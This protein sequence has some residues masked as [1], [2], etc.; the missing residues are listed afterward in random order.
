MRSTAVLLS[1]CLAA[2]GVL[3]AQEAKPAGAPEAQQAPTEAI[4]GPTF[5]V[6]KGT[7]ILLSMINSISTKTAADGDKVYLESVFP[8]LSGGKVVIPPG[9][10]V[11]G[12]VTHIKRPGK[13]KGRG[14]FYLKFDSLTLPNGTTRDFRAQITNL[15]GRASESLD[16][17]EG[18]IKSEGNKAGDAKTVGETVMIG[19]GVG[20]L[21]GSVAGS[22]GMG[23]G[24]G[25]AAGAAAGLLGVLLSRGPDAVLAKGTTLEMVLDRTLIFEESEIEFTAQMSRPGASNGSG[26]LPSKRL[27]NQVPGSRGPLGTRR[28]Y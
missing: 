23:A 10:Y 20:A 21:G 17:T 22:T 9:S 24:I 19:T 12:T 4:P 5:K 27:Q 15:D 2:E 7:N 8:I 11:A 26:P 16:K 25:A 18:R 14:E 1:A 28:P 6:E 3:L 13:V